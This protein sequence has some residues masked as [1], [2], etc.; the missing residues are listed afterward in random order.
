MNASSQTDYSGFAIFLHWLIALAIF[1]MLPLGLYMRELPLSPDKLTLYAYHKW[2]GMLILLLVLVRLAWRRL[3]PPP[4]APATM[5][6][7]EQRVAHGMVHGMYLFMLFVPLT[8]WLM[9][10]AFGKPVVMFGVL[11]LPDLVGADESL[12]KLFKILHEVG[13]Y[14]LCTLFSLHILAALKHHFKDHDEV[15]A[16]MLPFLKRSG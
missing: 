4:A 2:A 8:G 15:L 7:V 11:P 12:G 13:N 3:N 6:A 16:R 9:S 14:T 10:S 1:A 5:S